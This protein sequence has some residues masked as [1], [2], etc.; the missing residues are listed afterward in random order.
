[1]KPKAQKAFKLRSQDRMVIQ[2][3][4][5]TQLEKAFPNPTESIGRSRKLKKPRKPAM[6]IG[7]RTNSLFN[8]GVLLCSDQIDKSIQNETEFTCYADIQKVVQTDL[9]IKSHFQK[10]II[11]KLY[12]PGEPSRLHRRRRSHPQ[13][14]VVSTGAPTDINSDR[15]PLDDEQR[16]HQLLS[17]EMRYQ[18]SRY[19]AGGCSP[20]IVETNVLHLQS[21]IF[22]DYD[23]E[24][25]K[26]RQVDDVVAESTASS[27]NCMNEEY[28]GPNSRSFTISYDEQVKDV[29]SKSVVNIYRSM[30]GPTLPFYATQANIEII[31]Q[32]AKVGYTVVPP[33]ETARSFLEGSA[34]SNLR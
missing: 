33:P 7:S 3:D 11:N 21:N 9:D 25:F 34:G 27:Y 17:L 18:D 19:L 12:K 5:P 8:R 1:M 23:R 28:L 29:Q 26:E 16:Q 15:Y 10:E 32:K 30:L 31:N 14:D 6:Q 22:E 13:L 24:D 20:E 2:G 4:H